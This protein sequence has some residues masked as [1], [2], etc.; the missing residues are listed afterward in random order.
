MDTGWLAGTYV[1][2]SRSLYDGE[3]R[4]LPNLGMWLY[5][6]CEK[7]EEICRFDILYCLGDFLG[8]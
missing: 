7:A 3:Y 5:V 6:L 8:W 2:G 1:F 4:D